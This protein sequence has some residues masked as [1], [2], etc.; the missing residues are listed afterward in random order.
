MLR[1]LKSHKRT[2][3]CS[4]LEELKGIMISKT[5]ENS[6]DSDAIASVKTLDFVLE[7]GK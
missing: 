7:R 5:I 1:I 2:K 3:D 6:F 4:E